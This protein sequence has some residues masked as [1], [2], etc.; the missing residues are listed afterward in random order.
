M[1]EEQAPKKVYY[2]KRTNAFPV[3]HEAML[4]LFGLPDTARIL[5]FE[6]QPMRDR[7]IVHVDSHSEIIT[8][9]GE[10]FQSWKVA[11][12]TD[13]PY[14]CSAV[15]SLSQ[16]ERLVPKAWNSVRGEMSPEDFDEL[17]IQRKE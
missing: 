12:A 15:T 16:E 13:S 4:A 6:Y 7:Y 3:S 10:P 17:Y 5:A 1:V 9:C 11:E 2:E 8:F 14:M